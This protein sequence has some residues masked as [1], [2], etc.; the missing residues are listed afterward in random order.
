MPRQRL[1]VTGQV[2]GLLVA[3][4]IVGKDKSNRM[5]WLCKCKCGKTTK[6]VVSYLINGNTKSCGCLSKEVASK[7]H[8]IH[9]HFKGKKTT[10]EYNSYH[11]MIQR[12]TNSLQKSYD[13]YG[14]RGIKVCDQWANSFE[15][16]LQD[17]GERPEGTTLDRRDVNGNYEPKNCRW[18]TLKEQANNKRKH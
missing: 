13:N 4:M 6:V 3:E 2:F 10:P 18:A 17:M 15:A 8:T 9:G 7:T 1:D 12:C 16:F 14:G 5:K 11:S